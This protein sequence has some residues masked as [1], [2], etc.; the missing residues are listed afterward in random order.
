MTASNVSDSL[1][2]LNWK[3]NNWISFG[4]GAQEPWDVTHE[5]IE[6]ARVRGMARREVLELS[7][8]LVAAQRVRDVGKAEEI[9]LEASA[10]PPGGAPVDSPIARAEQT[11]EEAAAAEAKDAAKK[12]IEKLREAVPDFDPAKLFK[13]LLAL[14][15][16]EVW[17]VGGIIAALALVVPLLRVAVLVKELR[18]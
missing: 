4:D 2:W 11:L 3:A 18:R 6:A 7:N 8:E 10:W 13:E 9:Y 1:R 12:A 17:V 16:R 5:A 14:V 15:P